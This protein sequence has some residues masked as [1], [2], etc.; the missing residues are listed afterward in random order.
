MNETAHYQQNSPPGGG[1]LSSVVIERS[2]V[3]NDLDNSGLSTNPRPSVTE[4][5]FTRHQV[6]Y[7]FKFF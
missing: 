3:A 2:E 7:K 5:L 6:I 4:T 1:A